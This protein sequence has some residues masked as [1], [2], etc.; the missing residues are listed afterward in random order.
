MNAK[1][2]ETLRA[3]IDKVVKITTYDGE[4]LLAKVVLVS[5][6]DADVIYELVSTNRESRYE[7]FDVQPAYATQFKDIESVESVAHAPPIPLGPT[8]KSAK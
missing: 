7:K 2:L 4:L 6:E 8:G 5:E 1:D 3:N